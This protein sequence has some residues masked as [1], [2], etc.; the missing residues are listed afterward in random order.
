MN[1]EQIIVAKLAIASELLDIAKNWQEF[2]NGDLQAAIEAQVS[3]AIELG[4]DFYKAKI[5]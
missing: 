5:F 4:A 3:K 1:K 2:G